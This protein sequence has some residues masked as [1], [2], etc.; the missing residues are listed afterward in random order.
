[1]ARSVSSKVCAVPA[2]PP[3]I[4]AGMPIVRIVQSTAVSASLRDAPGARLNEIVVATKG[5]W[6]FT[7]N[8]VL[9]RPNEAMAERGTIVSSAVL[10]GAPDDALPL[11]VLAR[12]L[13]AALRA[14]LR[15]MVAAKSALFDAELMTVPTT[16]FVVSVPLA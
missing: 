5:P 13:L 8:G 10:T 9:S 4:D 2:K 12:E 14:E 15:A 11:P 7:A 1:M 3:W 16:A 6:W